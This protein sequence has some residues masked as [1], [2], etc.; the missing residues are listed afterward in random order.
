MYS[1]DAPQYA[2]VLNWRYKKAQVTI[3]YYNSLYNSASVQLSQYT[4]QKYGDI[5]KPG[6]EILQVGTGRYQVRAQLAEGEIAGL[7]YRIHNFSAV[8]HLS[9]RHQILASTSNQSLNLSH[10]CVNEQRSHTTVDCH[11]I[12]FGLPTLPTISTGNHATLTCTLM[13]PFP[14]TI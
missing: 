9:P 8:T 1:A 4:H 2:I 14:L 12:G 7:V 10:V 3:Y 6:C 11:L 13:L 5:V